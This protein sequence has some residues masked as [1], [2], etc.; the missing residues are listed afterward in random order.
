MRR[1]RID[2]HQS[3]RPSPHAGPITMQSFAHPPSDQRT[4]NGKEKKEKIGNEEITTVLVNGQIDKRNV[5]KGGRA[6]NNVE[7]T[8][9]SACGSAADECRQGTEGHRKEEASEEAE[10]DK[11]DNLHVE[12]GARE[13][14]DEAVKQI[15]CVD[16]LQGGC[17]AKSMNGHI[18]ER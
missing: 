7:N 12:I 16:C 15:E 1:L 6:G 2:T 10:D 4:G 14:L 9:G 13:D 3:D 11:S 18:D 5:D 8:H 17:K